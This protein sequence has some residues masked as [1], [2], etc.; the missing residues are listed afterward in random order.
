[1][2]GLAWKPIGAS[3]MYTF[4][5]L[6]MVMG[7]NQL[8]RIGMYW[9]THPMVGGPKIFCSQV[10]SRGRFLCILKF[11]RFGPPHLVEKGKPKSRIEPFLNILRSKCK[12]IPS[13]R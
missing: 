9:S 11:L 7:I 12:D 4:L 2:N 6:L 5:G 3:E 10:I 13:V 1:M 8:P